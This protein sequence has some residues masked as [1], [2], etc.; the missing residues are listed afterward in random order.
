M[1]CLPWFRCLP[2]F[3]L[4]P[5]LSG[6][7]VARNAGIFAVQMM[8]TENTDLAEKLVTFKADMAAGVVKKSEKLQEKLKAD[9]LA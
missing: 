4:R 1:P 7:P 9:G 5:W 2:A 3:R 8:S 6:R